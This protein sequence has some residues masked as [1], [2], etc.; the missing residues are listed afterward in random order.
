[1]FVFHTRLLLP[2]TVQLDLKTNFK[3]LVVFVLF[4]VKGMDTVTVHVFRMSTRARVSCASHTHHD[5]TEVRIA[6]TDTTK[7][8]AV[9]PIYLTLGE[10]FFF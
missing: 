8:N 7:R 9:S 2:E 5:V 1:M 3:F 10:I 6:I 4:S